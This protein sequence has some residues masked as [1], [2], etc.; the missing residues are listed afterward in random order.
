MKDVIY[1]VRRLMSASGQEE[2]S[3]ATAA[4]YKK[5]IEEEYV[6]FNDA[7]TPVEEFDACL[8]MIWVIV[9]YM[10]AKGWLIR[11]GWQEVV[12]SNLSKIPEDGVM[13]LR[14]DGK[15]LKPDSYSPPDLER[16]LR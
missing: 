12:R 9:A 1:P 2:H 15:F 4:L 7:E 14:E 6:E 11:S 8:D 5:L 13:L 10:L 3:E 16:F